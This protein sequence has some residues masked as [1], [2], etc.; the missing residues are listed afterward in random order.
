MGPPQRPPLLRA[1]PGTPP[2]PEDQ[3]PVAA[4]EW[5]SRI[6]GERI[7]AALAIR[8][9]QERP[10]GGPGNRRLGYKLVGP[11]KQRH[12][13]PDWDERGV[14]ARILDLHEQQGLGFHAIGRLLEAERCGRNGGP[15]VYTESRCRQYYAAWKRIIAWE[16]L[17]KALASAPPAPQ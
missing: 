2:P 4:A 15:I 9:G 11:P 14:M 8:M 12:Y 6:K 1:I 7:K 16:G 13:V 10:L 5:E 3:G 17:E